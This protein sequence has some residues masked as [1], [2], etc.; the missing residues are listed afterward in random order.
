[1]EKKLEPNYGDGYRLF[2]KAE[3]HYASNHVREFN[4]KDEIVKGRVQ[5]S[6][7]SIEYKVEVKLNLIACC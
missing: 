5:A 3:K 4:L 6:Q 7:K 1:M 2:R